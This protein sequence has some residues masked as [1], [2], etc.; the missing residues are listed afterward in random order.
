MRLTGR[1][2]GKIVGRPKIFGRFIFAGRE[3]G[4]ILGRMDFRPKIFGRL[5]FAQLAEESVS[6][7]ICTG[8]PGRGLYHPACG[9]FPPI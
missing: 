7:V 3:K 1:E 4:K 6:K 9:F 8:R 5:I 2:K